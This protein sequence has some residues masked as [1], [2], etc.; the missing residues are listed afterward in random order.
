MMIVKINETGQDGTRI[1]HGRARPSCWSQG[2]SRKALLDAAAR[3]FIHGCQLDSSSGEIAF[4][5]PTSIG[6]KV[7]EKWGRGGVRI[8]RE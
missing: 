1:C 3:T 4:S 5:Q 8:Y 6:R 2:T 7:M